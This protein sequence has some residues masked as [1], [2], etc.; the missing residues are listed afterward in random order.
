M[1]K[2]PLADDSVAARVTKRHHPKPFDLLPEHFPLVCAHLSVKDIRALLATQRSWFRAISDQ[3]AAL[4]AIHPA[5]ETEK[6]GFRSEKLKYLAK[7]DGGGCIYGVPWYMYLEYWSKENL[8]PSNKTDA[9]DRWL[10]MSL[11]RLPWRYALD[12]LE[13]YSPD[14]TNN[15]DLDTY[16][17]SVEPLPTQD[18]VAVK[19]AYAMHCEHLWRETVP[20][21]LEDA[22]MRQELLAWLHITSILVSG[23]SGNVALLSGLREDFKVTLN[24]CPGYLGEGFG[25][26][27]IMALFDL[28]PCDFFNCRWKDLTPISDTEMSTLRSLARLCGETLPPR[29]QFPVLIDETYAFLPD[30][31]AFINLNKG[32]R[33]PEDLARWRELVTLMLFQDRKAQAARGFY[34]PPGLL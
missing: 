18:R 6:G 26:V 24:K 15:S 13:S 7:R 11:L 34:R 28:G 30:L 25:T 20:Y 14:P 29:P 19:T 1:S 10:I 32:N 8:S 12:M 9:W 17:S 33:D 23:D 27:P 3:A 31:C 22:P 16:L 5:F 4:V 2:R 21:R